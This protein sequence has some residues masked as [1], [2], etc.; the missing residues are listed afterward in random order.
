MQLENSTRKLCLNAMN[1]NILKISETALT[2]FTDS[3]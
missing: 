3:I 1:V 2:A